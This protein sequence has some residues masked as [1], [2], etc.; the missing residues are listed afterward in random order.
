MTKL[1]HLHRKL[2][3]G[4]EYHYFDTGQRNADGRKIFSP[5]A[6]PRSPEFPRA[7]AMACEARKRRQNVIPVRTFDWLLKA[8]EKSPEFRKKKPNTQR[9]Y[10]NA[11]AKASKLLRDGEGRSTPL[12]QI[13]ARDILNIRDKLID[14]QGANQTVRCLSA[15]FTWA[16]HKA[17]RFMPENPADEI[18]LFDEGEQDAWPEWLVETALQDERVRPI[19]G[20]LYFTG[21]RIGDVL[22]LRWSDI[23]AG[24]IELVQ[25]KTGKPL[26]IPV[27]VELQTILDQIP[28]RGLTILAK[29]T[30][31][32]YS[33]N[34]IRPK[35][36]TWIRGHGTE[37][38]MHGLRKNAVNAL[39]YA[40]CSTAE[41]SAITGQSLKMVEHYAKQ[42]DQAVLGEAAILKL[43]TARQKR[44][45]ERT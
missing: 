43:D 26:K 28:K 32:P 17:R 31:D 24:S 1:K 34:G 9:S 22:T 4:R 11:F 23:R 45:K 15:L 39:L 10:L 33:Y 12:D 13:E 25:E 27:A 30:G 18:E 14:G 5:I 20:L 8:Y 3:K 21:Q 38:V 35:L 36:K 6:H 42:R 19:V 7:Y 16:S 29:S 2:V 44:I 41:V 40:G 37:D